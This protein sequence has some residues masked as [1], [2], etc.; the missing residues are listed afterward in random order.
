MVG[1]PV[2]NATLKGTVQS[3]SLD[4]STGIDAPSHTV[5]TQDLRYGKSGDEADLYTN[6]RY[7]VFFVGANK[8]GVNDNSITVLPAPATASPQILGAASD[9]TE[10]DIAAKGDVVTLTATFSDDPVDV[11]TVLV[12]WGDGSAPREA[13]IE[14]DGDLFTVTAVHAYSA[15]GIFPITLTV[16]DDTGLTDT[17]TATAHVAGVGMVGNELHVIGTN[18][19]D[20]VEITD[21]LGVPQ[22]F[23][24]FDEYFQPRTVVDRIRVEL[25]GGDDTVFVSSAV[26]RETL[27]DGGAGTDAFTSDMPLVAGPEGSFR[28]PGTGIVGVNFEVLAGVTEIE[29]SDNGDSIAIY[30]DRVEINGSTLLLG[31]LGNLTVRPGAGDDQIGVFLEGGHSATTRPEVTIVD[32]GGD[33]TYIVAGSRVAIDLQDIAGTDML[34]FSGLS[35]PLILHLWRDNGVRQTLGASQVR[36]GLNGTFE[37]VI[38]TPYNDVIFGNSA[39]NTLYGGA[40]DDLLWGRDGDDVLHGGADRD[41]LFGEAGDDLLD[42]GAGNDLLWGNDGNDELH[43]GEGED[44]LSGGRGDDVLVSRAGRDLL[45][46]HSGNDILSVPDGDLSNRHLD[47]GTGTDTLRLDASD[48]TLDLRIQNHHL[49]RNIEQ[50]DLRGS[51]D[52]Q[53]ILDYHGV[54]RLSPSSDTLMVR[55]NEGDAV[56]I[57][58]GWTQQ[59]DEF[60]FGSRFEVFQQRSAIVKIEAVEPAGNGVGTLTVH[61]SLDVNRDGYVTPLDAL[62]VISFLNSADPNGPLRDAADVTGDA[63]VS[64]LDALTIISYLNSGMANTGPEGE[65]SQAPRSELA[66]SA[67]HAK[68]DPQ[69]QQDKSVFN[70]ESLNIVDEAFASYRFGF[71]PN[72]QAGWRG[73]M[74][75]DSISERDQLNF[76]D[77]FGQLD[78]ILDD[79]F[80]TLDAGDSTAERIPHNR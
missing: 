20:R 1:I 53:L 7:S 15:G 9:A 29:G 44:L 78:G 45:F 43:G 64:P 61:H 41:R 62:L 11:H 23:T 65:S 49:P 56:T 12:D 32:A 58:S 5:S 19:D 27:I 35:H 37:N 25:F 63:F 17:E 79:I 30:N 14:Q 36:V 51:G 55:R 77:A 13:T 71:P 68:N 2:A 70:V 40:G 60:H 54:R 69:G 34:D 33:D 76:D 74:P 52:N 50:I 4:D 24:N 16:T 6:E 59:P 46:G 10:L 21:L 66:T 22:V 75:G 47:G 31:N 39:D 28:V 73:R 38:G 18:G 80:G 72:N 26:D 42:G 48:A 3:L 57:G 67:T 8:R